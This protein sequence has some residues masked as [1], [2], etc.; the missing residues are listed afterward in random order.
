MTVNNIKGLTRPLIS[1]ILAG[2]VVWFTYTGMI[3]IEWFLGIATVALGWWY[4]D[5]TVEKKA[6]TVPK[7][8]AG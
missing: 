6:V 8:A 5:R 7:E 4:R 3:E 1:V 2:A